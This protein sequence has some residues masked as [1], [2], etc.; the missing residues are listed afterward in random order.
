MVSN[1]VRQRTKERNLINIVNECRLML[2]TDRCVNACHDFTLISTK[3]L[4]KFVNILIVN[5]GKNMIDSSLKL[6]VLAG[7]LLLLAGNASAATFTNVP[8]GATSGLPFI[9]FGNAANPSGDS[10]KVGEVFSLISNSTLSSFSFYAL[11]N[12]TSSLQL[13]VAQWN[14]DTNAKNQVTNLVGSSLLTTTGSAVETFNSTGGFT[15]ISFNNLGLNLN[16]N[17]KYIA[18]LTSNDPTVTGIQFS[19]TQTTADTSGFG[20]GNAYLSTVPGTGW[21][22]PFNGNGFLSLQYTAVTAAVP[23]AD[24]SAMMLAG[25]GLMGFMARRR[26][27]QQM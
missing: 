18:Y 12:I 3:L 6:K 2:K 10:P 20:I 9:S 25:L 27:K 7:F 24:T 14:P 23:E 26:K 19:R 22:L 13:N 16:S 1:D 17:T 11:G 8:S 21:Q 5:K 4:H 15:T